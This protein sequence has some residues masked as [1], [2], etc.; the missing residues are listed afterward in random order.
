M[1]NWYSYATLAQ[2]KAEYIA[3]K[4]DDDSYLI[5][6]LR[7]VTARFETETGRVFVP[8]IET[9]YFDAIGDHNI[10]NGEKRLMLRDD[11]LEATTVTDGSGTVLL[12]GT[13]YRTHPRAGSPSYALQGLSTY[14]GWHQYTSDPYEAISVAGVWGYHEDYTNA[15]R[16]S[17]Q[18]ASTTI[19][20][21]DTTF[22]VSDAD[23]VDPYTGA[24]LFS[25]G[26]LLKVE[27]E[28]MTLL[29]ISTNTLTVQRG[30]NGSTAAA[31]SSA[32]SVYIWQVE[33]E[34]Q[35]VVAREASFILKRRAIFEQAQFES[36]AGGGVV[37]QYPKDLEHEWQ[38]AV[39]RFRRLEWMGI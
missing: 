9:K 15:W 28:Y 37:V 33:P 29:S 10:F 35:R 18:D 17:G 13:D 20:A 8:R 34:V 21:S 12:S 30:A 3:T 25:P 14:A 11:L 31:H 2:A 27:N 16:D 23:A 36:G 7:Q 5:N 1:N 19:G 6:A 26:Q 24:A 38:N 22:A 39:N 32:L 4:T